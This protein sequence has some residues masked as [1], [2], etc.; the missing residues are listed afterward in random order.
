MQR[1]RFDE[2]EKMRKVEI[3]QRLKAERELSQEIVSTLR[4]ST[5]GSFD[6]RKSLSQSAS[7]NIVGGG[8]GGGSRSSNNNNRYDGESFFVTEEEDH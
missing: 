2:L 6:A 1:K 7:R 4:M 5:S 3:L 8:S